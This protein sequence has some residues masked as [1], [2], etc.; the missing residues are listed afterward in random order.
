MHF[1]LNSIGKK[2]LNNKDDNFYYMEL[3]LLYY[4][5]CS[6]IYYIIKRFYSNTIYIVIYYK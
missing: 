1:V 5:L 4:L 6:H 2:L 3:E